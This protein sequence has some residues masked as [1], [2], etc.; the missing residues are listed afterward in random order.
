MVPKEI[1]YEY[2]EAV[3]MFSS[4]FQDIINQCFPTIETIHDIAL[5]VI[6]ST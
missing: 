2:N 5:H 6:T 4:C 3:I 1:I